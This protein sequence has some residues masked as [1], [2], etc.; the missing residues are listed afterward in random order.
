MAENH[1]EPYPQLSESAHDMHRALQSVKEELD[2][3]DWYN[4]RID[5]TPDAELKGLL[6]HNRDEEKEHAVMILEWIR[7]R[8]A[9]LDQVMRTYLFTQ[10]DLLQIEEQSDA[11]EAGQAVVAEAK[12]TPTFGRL[13]V[14]SLK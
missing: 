10:G 7:R 9:A 8:D 12:P 14:G 2:A 1:H 5:V 6:I 4:Q 3:I 13:T 11:E